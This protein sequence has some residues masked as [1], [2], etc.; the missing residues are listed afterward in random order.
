MSVVFETILE[1]VCLM[2]AGY[3]V[4]L[5]QEGFDAKDR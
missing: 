3:V 4:R 5:F 2:G 1:A